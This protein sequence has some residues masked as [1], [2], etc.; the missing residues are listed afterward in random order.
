MSNEAINHTVKL[1]VKD[2][3]YYITLD[4]KGLAISSQF[5]YLS[6]LKYYLTGYTLDQYGNPV[7][8]LADV[9]VDAYQKNSDGSLIS[10]SFGTNYPDQVTFELIPEAL[11]NGYVPLQVFVPIM[12]SI[13]A[14]TG[15]Q[16]VFLK[17]DWSTLKSTT[18]DDPDFT[19]NNNNNSSLG[20]GSTLGSGSSLTSSGSGLKSGSS[21]SSASNSTGSTLKA[22]NAKTGDEAPIS[23]LVFLALLALCMGSLAVYGKRQEKK[24]QN[25]ERK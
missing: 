20:S 25:T 10:D 14:G 7:G 19:D 15:T 5:G 4:F 13:S 11:E 24:C 12:E 16:P 2:G 17:L 3:K 18:A 22:S 9:T 6:Q 23:G 1:T 8:T 21:L